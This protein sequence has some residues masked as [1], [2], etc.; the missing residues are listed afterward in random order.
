MNQS[1]L[2]LSNLIF[3]NWKLE[4]QTLGLTPGSEEKQDGCFPIYSY[5]DW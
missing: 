2:D 4:A 5:V 1:I 3:A